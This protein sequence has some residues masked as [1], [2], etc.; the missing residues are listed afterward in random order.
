MS[1]HSPL[2][3]HTIK[4]STLRDE[5]QVLGQMAVAH[6]LSPLCGRA[7]TA[8]PETPQGML[9]N[10]LDGTPCI[11]TWVWEALRKTEEV[12]LELTP[13]FNNSHNLQA[14]PMTRC[15]IEDERRRSRPSL[16]FGGGYGALWFSECRMCICSQNLGFRNLNQACPV[17]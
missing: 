4:L 3:H 1:H 12:C 17:A 6:F 2:A 9:Q 15:A 8:A 11:I 7:A 16:E 13:T 5:G 10:V 14:T